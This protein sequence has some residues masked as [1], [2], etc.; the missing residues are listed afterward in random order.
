[1]DA[2]SGETHGEH[3]KKDGERRQPVPAR[4]A[5]GPADD[6][7]A[8]GMV[9]VGGGTREAA[10]G[11]GRDDDAELR[12]W[13]RLARSR[14]LPRRAGELA[15][16]AGGGA[17]FAEPSLPFLRGLGTSRREQ[18]RLLDRKLD[19]ALRRGL[20]IA[21]E[22]GW[23]L[24]H[25]AHPNYP[26]LLAEI[27]DPPPVLAVL[28]DPAALARPAVAIVG[29]RA[30]SPWGLAFA[31]RLAGELAAL[32]LVVAS[33]LARGI[34]GAAHRGALEAAGTTVAVIGSGL[35]RVYPE[36]HRELAERIAS[37]GGAV[38]SEFAWDH[39]PLPRNFLQ[40][41]RV[42]SGLALGV[43]V[44]EAGRRS[45]SLSTAAHAVGQGRQV[46]A[47]PGRAGD[48]LAAGC[49][50][51]LRDGA[52]LVRD[53]ADVLAELP[54]AFRPDAP[55]PGADE[56]GTARPGPGETPLPPGLDPA[57]GDLLARVPPGEEI[58]VDRLLEEDARPPDRVLADLFTLEVAGL[59]EALPGGRF[60][61]RP[62]GPLR[63]DPV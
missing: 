49:L 4:N 21:R 45:G 24:L 46:M 23:T 29:A 48:P 36:E 25:R 31:A 47:V 11:T 38:V 44:V 62:P 13:L 6:D 53:A 12:G 35:D 14:L 55:P 33:G 60:R 54:P 39:A 37:A 26:A 9:P 28:G 34:D 59:L 51:L 17:P 8:S 56:P 30:A 3:G 43:V 7:P 52:A 40:R 57:L 32:G 63:Q 15:E 5:A 18:R 19:R 61:R 10:T 2:R 42:I 22:R 58:H 1:M 16:L 41:N 20:A 50:D 27:P